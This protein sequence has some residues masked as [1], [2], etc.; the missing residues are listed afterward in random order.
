MFI[1]AVC[2]AG[3]SGRQFNIFIVKFILYSS[4]KKKKKIMKS[5]EGKPITKF[6]FFKPLRSSSVQ[7]G[8][9]HRGEKVQGLDQ[10]AR[11]CQPYAPTTATARYQSQDNDAAGGPSHPGGEQSRKAP[12]NVQQHL[13]HHFVRCLHEYPDSF[14]HVWCRNQFHLEFHRHRRYHQNVRFD[15]FQCQSLHHQLAEFPAEP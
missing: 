15:G 9:C 5:F 10:D 2:Q 11:L 12:A 8:L 13:S 7:K 6:N 14:C 4:Q 1:K 3:E